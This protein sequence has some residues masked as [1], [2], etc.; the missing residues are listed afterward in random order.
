MSAETIFRA[1]D[2]IG[3][4]FIVGRKGLPGKIEIF[5]NGVRLIFFILS[6]V[7]NIT[8]DLL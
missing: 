3:L 4:K 2:S 8:I 5:K 7:N 1:N 6:L